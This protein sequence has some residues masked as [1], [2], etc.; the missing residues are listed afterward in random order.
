MQVHRKGKKMPRK[1]TITIEII[2]EH[3]FVM[4]REK[5]MEAISA[6]NLAKHVGCSTQPIFRVYKNMEELSVQVYA[7]SISYFHEYYEKAPRFSKVPFVN[8]GLAYISFANEEKHMFRLLFLSTFKYKKSLY[9]ILNGTSGIVNKEISLANNEGCVDAQTLFMN[10]WIFIQGA[11]AMN[12]T[13][14]YDLSKK[15]TLRLLE[16]TYAA[17]M[18]EIVKE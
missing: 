1:E 17:F 8:L 15:E 2:L 13:D 12:L 14:D 11:A 5:G 6:R 9:E 7:K 10:M 3:A 16:S 18:N 4:L